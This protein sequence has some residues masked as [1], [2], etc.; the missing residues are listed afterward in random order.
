MIPTHK[1]EA[2]IYLEKA[3]EL[4]NTGVVDQNNYQSNCGGNRAAVVPY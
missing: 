4:K 2:E 1:F 3:I